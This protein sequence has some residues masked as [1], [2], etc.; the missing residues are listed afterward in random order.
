MA[1]RSRS[2]K[3]HLQTAVGQE[4]AVRSRIKK[5]HLQRQQSGRKLEEVAGQV[6]RRVSDEYYSRRLLYEVAVKIIAGTYSRRVADRW[7]GIIVVMD[8]LR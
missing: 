2:K 6:S 1:V 3:V 5:E 7:S 4:A 8:V